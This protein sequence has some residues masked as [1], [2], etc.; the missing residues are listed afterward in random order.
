MLRSDMTLAAKECVKS[1][2]VFILVFPLS[3]WIGWQTTALRCAAHCCKI[4]RRL[5]GKDFI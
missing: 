2:F 5:V 4:E 3:Q 1:V